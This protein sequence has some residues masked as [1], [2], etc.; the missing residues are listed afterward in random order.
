MLYEKV[1]ISHLPIGFDRQT[2]KKSC[3]LMSGIPPGILNDPELR[4][5]YSAVEEVRAE[6]AVVANFLK[7][8]FCA[9]FRSQMRAGDSSEA[10]RWIEAFEL[11]SAEVG[12]NGKKETERFADRMHDDLK[13]W[14]LV[15]DFSS[16]ML[17]KLNVLKAIYYGM[18]AGGANDLNAKA[19]EIASW[20][21]EVKQ[22]MGGKTSTTRLTDTRERIDPSFDTEVA[23][24]LLE[25]TGYSPSA[26][27]PRL[28]ADRKA[29]IEDR[30]SEAYKFLQECDKAGSLSAL[31]NALK[32]W[33]PN[34]H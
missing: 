4:E 19:S 23:L 9:R 20:A 28:T 24:A 33:N 16:E 11:E 27:A 12:D 7:R 13:V 10:E 25:S 14:Y 15:G 1:A 29:K 30:V 21:T 32:I 2:H 8:Q 3:H 26:S 5:L 18:C 22:A 34:G 6:S 17:K 31:Q